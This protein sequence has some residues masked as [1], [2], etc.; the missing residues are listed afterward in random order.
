[1]IVVTNFFHIHNGMC[2]VMIMK[3]SC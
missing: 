1:M 2:H 3:V